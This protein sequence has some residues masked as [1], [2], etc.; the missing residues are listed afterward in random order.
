MKDMIIGGFP[1]ELNVLASVGPMCTTLRDCD[2]F[3]RV[4]KETKPHLIDPRI[5]PIDWTGLSTQVKLPL[6]VGI[7]KHDEAIIPQPPVL[8]ALEWAGKQLSSSNDVILK[9]YTPYKASTAME[10]IRKAYW[11]ESGI[12]DKQMCESSGEPMHPLTAWIIKDASDDVQRTGQ[13]VNDMRWARDNFRSDFVQ[14]WNEQD[15]DFVI[16]PMF[17]G[18]ACAHDT[19][20]YCKSICRCGHCRVLM[21]A[22]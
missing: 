4:N 14:H 12:M 13:E 18:P 10:N 9:P 2:L 5:V 21:S 7:M 15:V 17:V 3:V 16:G 19:A 20:F 6:K 8:K 11:P 22:D 1:A